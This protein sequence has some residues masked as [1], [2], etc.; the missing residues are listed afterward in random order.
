MK[1]SFLSLLLVALGS[2]ATSPAAI[3]TSSVD[4]FSVSSEGW[5]IGG[6]GV[7]PVQVAAAGPDGETGYLSHFSDGGGA[8]GKWLMWSDQSEWQGDYLS[9]GV[10]GISL[11]ANVSAGISPVALRIAFDGP[12]GWFTSTAQ[13]AGAGWTNFNFILDA[14]NFSY[15]SSSGGTGSFASTMGGVTRFEILSGGG[16]V[17]YRAGGDIVQAGTSV[18]TI[19]VDTIQAVPEPSTYALLA[20]SAVGL[21]GHVLRRRR[22]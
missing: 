18:N 11:W 17:G 7:Q 1:A 2:A 5:Q 20:L 8:N 10:T 16:G 15:V 22:R 13:S 21:G 3:T 12:G 9:A 4:D 14:A 19:L 6:A